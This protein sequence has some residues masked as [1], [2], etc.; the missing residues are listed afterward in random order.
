MSISINI[1]KAKNIWKD[2]WR[3]A[4]KPLLNALDVEFVR[5]LESGDIVKQSEIS[6]KKQA[7]RDVTQTPINATTPD[8]IKN[9]WPSSLN[10]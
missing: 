4:R 8:E 2:K 7:L 5:A 1:D 6:A 9:V 3:D 10:G